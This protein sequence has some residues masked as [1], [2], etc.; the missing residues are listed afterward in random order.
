[1]LGSTFSLL[2]SEPR[3]RHFRVIYRNRADRALC[4][5]CHS[6]FL[7]PCDLILLAK[8]AEMSWIWKGNNMTGPLDERLAGLPTLS[9]AALSELWKQLFAADP[10]PLRRQLMIPVLAYR[11]QEAEFGSMRASTQLRMRQLAR[12]LQPRSNEMTT[13]VPKL[14]PG[15]RLVRQWRD[16]V[17]LVNI[18]D[19]GFEYH[20]NRYSSLSEIARRITGTRWSGPAFFGLKNERAS[21]QKE[22]R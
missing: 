21:Q 14:R 4:Q 22:I 3:F 6:P 13:T 20:G 18:D 2:P 7:H 8:E 15:T 10:P 5:V 17:H 9:K 11:L 12:A 19:Q 1:M 16:Q